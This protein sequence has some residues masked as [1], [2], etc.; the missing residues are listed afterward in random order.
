M[1]LPCN[2]AVTVDNN[3]IIWAKAKPV[4]CT[5]IEIDIYNQI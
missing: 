4:E 2:I 5:I 3:Y 1:K